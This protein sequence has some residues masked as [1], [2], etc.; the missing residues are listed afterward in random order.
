MRRR[1][2]A[3][4]VLGAGGWPL[5]AGAQQPSKVPTIGVLVVGSPGSDSFW[6]LFRESMHDLGYIDGRTVRYE[7]RSDSG[8][9]SRL[10]ELA[11]DLA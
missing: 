5:A 4:L 10:P 7:F 2:F 11:S 6:Q 1:G 3:R 8:Q 9:A